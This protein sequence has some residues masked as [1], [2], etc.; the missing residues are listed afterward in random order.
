[1]ACEGHSEEGRCSE[2]EGVSTDNDA[3]D[4]MFD[5]SASECDIEV[6]GEEGHECAP[7]KTKWRRAPSPD[8]PILNPT[9][10]ILKT[11]SKCLTLDLVYRRRLTAMLAFLRFY[12]HG[13]G[14]T[15]NAASLLAAVASGKGLGLAHSLHVWTW[16]FPEDNDQLSVS[17]HGKHNT[18][19]LLDE[20]LAAEIHEH[21][22]SLRKK[23]PQGHGYSLV[24]GA[25]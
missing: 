10:L 23:I 24:S 22:K 1:M 6:T 20:D 9:I 17:L 21:L 8:S 14:T 3:A 18:S 15:W 5:D 4:G 16:E 7:A 11:R 13:Y 25:T 19:R 2:A 12:T